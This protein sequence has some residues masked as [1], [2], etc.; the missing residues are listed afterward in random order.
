MSPATAAE[1][2][3]LTTDAEGVIRV[4]RTRVTLDTVVAAYRKGDTPEQ[5]AQDYSSL[6]A[7]DIYAVIAYYLRHQDEVAAYLARREQQADAVRRKFQAL[8]PA[9][10]LRERLQNRLG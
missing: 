8:F 1:P 3:P 2:V 5:I 7:A 4:G 6:Q 10:G 9:E